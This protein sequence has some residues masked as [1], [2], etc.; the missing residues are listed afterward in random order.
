[1]HDF[2]SQPAQPIEQINQIL[3]GYLSQPL[4]F[5]SVINMC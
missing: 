2:L 4:D 3:F 1:M 5:E